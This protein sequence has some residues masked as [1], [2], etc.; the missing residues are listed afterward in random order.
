MVSVLLELLED[1]PIDQRLASFKVV[2]PIP[3]NALRDQ[4]HFCN[5]GYTKDLAV[6]KLRCCIFR[7][8][9]PLLGSQVLIFECELFL[10]RFKLM[11]GR[12]NTLINVSLFSTG[13]PRPKLT[14]FLS[15]RLLTSY[16]TLY[17][18]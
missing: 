4:L 17:H 7:Q 3:L 6:Y 8:P 15:R 1:S 14:P 18:V 5:T 9:F 11:S 12:L 13:T 10:T 2:F 16:H